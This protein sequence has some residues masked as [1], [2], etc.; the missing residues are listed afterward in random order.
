[1][2]VA[3]EE[4]PSTIQASQS[5]LIYTLA[6]TWINYPAYLMVETVAPSPVRQSDRRTRIAITAV[7][8]DGG[9]RATSKPITVTNQIIDGTGRFEFAP[10]AT[11]RLW[12][13][14]EP[15]RYHMNIEQVITVTK[16]NK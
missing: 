2:D 11:S 16:A 4:L 12:Q 8:V 9:E 14:M 15:V 5:S 1:M 3:V 13:L 6:H 7:E 10:P